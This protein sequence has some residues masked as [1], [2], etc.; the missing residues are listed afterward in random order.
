[1][2]L[3]VTTDSAPNCKAA[4]QLIMEAYPHITWSPCVAH[5]CDL[6]L[7]DIFKLDYFKRPHIETKEYI[8]FIKCVIPCS[9]VKGGGVT[10]HDPGVTC[11]NHHATLAAWRL[12][13]PEDLTAEL[14]S[15]AL[16]E[17]KAIKELQLLKPGDTRFAT[18]LIVLERIQRVRSKLEQFVVSDRFR[19][20]VAGMKVA[21]QVRVC[22]Q[23]LLAAV[24]G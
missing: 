13:S 12:M 21:D 3:Q 8:T 20:A 17:F 14:S 1:M 24:K 10:S 16:E 18:A 22:S 6:A 7:E 9:H 23:L 5:I 19:E 11:R 15:E 4:G 2:R